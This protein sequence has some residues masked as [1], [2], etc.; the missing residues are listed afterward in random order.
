MPRAGATLLT[1]ILG[2]VLGAIFFLVTLGPAIVRPTN[3]GWVMRHDTQTYLLSWHHFRREP[4]Q[5]PPGKVLSV[6]HPV[7]TT[8]GNT[9]A[10]PILALPLK[11]LHRV[12]PDPAQYLG[13]W[14]LTCFILQGVFGALLV[15]LVTPDPIIQVLGAGLFVQTPALLHR[16]G[17]TALCA[18]WMLLAAIWLC[19]AHPLRAFR[20]RV[21]AWT[22]L[23]SAVALTQP[24]LGAMVVA[25]AMA[26]LASDGFEA[27]RSGRRWVGVVGSAAVVAAAMAASLWL[28]GYFVVGSSSDLGLGGLGDYS[29]NLLSPITPMGTRRSSPR[30][31]PPHPGSTRASS[32]SAPAGSP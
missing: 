31:P 6:G 8:I 4:W 5:W 15:R 24:Y 28:A 14:L 9:D 13:A 1:P 22:L 20:W 16:N 19:M 23:C 2:G 32:T 12:L 21:V 25:L 3:L 11:T 7:G 10:I 26:D 17:H 29:M 18:H 30:S 27:W